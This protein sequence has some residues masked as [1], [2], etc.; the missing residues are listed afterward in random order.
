MGHEQIG[1]GFDRL[2]DDV[3]RRV[4]GEQD[5]V[6]LVGRVAGHEAD[7]V[8]LLGSMRVVGGLEYSLHLGDRGSSRH[9]PQSIA[10]RRSR[11]ASRVSA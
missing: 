8:P 4:H 9:P 5:P 11:D 7:G 10:C 2:V 1:A 6:D 3:V